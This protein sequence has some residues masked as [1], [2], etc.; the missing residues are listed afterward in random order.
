MSHP[1]GNDPSLAREAAR[2]AAPP[3]VGPPAKLGK[4]KRRP[5]PSQIVFYSYPKFLYTW[6]VI[7]LA[8]LLPLL[9]DWLNPQLEGWIFVITLL[10]VLMAMGFDLSR[11]LTI[12]WGV[13]ILASVFCLLWLKDT[14]NVMIFSQFGHHLSSKAPLISHD[15]LDLFGLFGGI[16]YLIMWLDA[17]I[18][19]RWRI[20]HNE[21][22]HFAMLSKDDSL[23]RGAKRIITSYP[24]FLELLLCGAGTIQ[25]YSAQGGVELRSIPNVPWLF[26]RSARISQILESTEVSAASGEDDVDLHEG[27]AANEELSDGHGG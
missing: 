22:E 6:P 13:T 14:Q 23:G 4:A 21:I 10:T 9:G 11:N 27:Q 7:V 15:W 17:H 26:F 16:L 18:N 19:Q 20:S 2:A 3:A 8:L 12:T 24:D 25:I 5:V 1:E